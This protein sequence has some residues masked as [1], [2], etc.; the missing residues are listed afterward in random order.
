MRQYLRH[1]DSNCDMLSQAKCFILNKL[2]KIATRDTKKRAAL[3]NNHYAK[4][5]TQHPQPT[6]TPHAPSYHIH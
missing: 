1:S 3:T 2:F 6:T 5:I 4:P